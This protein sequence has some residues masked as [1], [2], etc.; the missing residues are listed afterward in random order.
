M[1]HFRSINKYHLDGF[2]N[3]YIVK[4]E[5]PVPRTVFGKWIGKKVEI[6]GF[7]GTVKGVESNMV[8]DFVPQDT[9]GILA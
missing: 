3:I 8:G 7:V 4:L 5:P 9:I 2:G 6:D 1:L